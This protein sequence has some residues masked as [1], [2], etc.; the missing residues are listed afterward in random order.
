MRL[1]RQ[2]VGGDLLLFNK[3]QELCP[4]AVSRLF[5][6]KIH[7]CCMGKHDMPCT[8]N[9]SVSG[10][11]A[12][13]P[14]SPVSTALHHIRV[15][16]GEEAANHCK[17]VLEERNLSIAAKWELI[18]HRRRLAVQRSMSQE[19]RLFRRRR[20]ADEA[21]VKRRFGDLPPD[22]GDDSHWT[23]TTAKWLRRYFACTTQVWSILLRAQ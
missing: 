9:P 16:C 23:S 1:K 21:R 4:T 8:F 11:R 7:T 18:L 6:V 2:Y 3:L 20:R 19:K 15:A 17:R 12:L 5:A 10:G 14:Q 13:K 22:S